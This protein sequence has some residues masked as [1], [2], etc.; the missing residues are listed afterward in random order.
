MLSSVDFLFSSDGQLTCVLK[1]FSVGG[2]LPR[3]PGSLGTEGAVGGNIALT[4]VWGLIP[5]G[6]LS[7]SSLVLSESCSCVGYKVS[8]QFREKL[9]VEASSKSDSSTAALASN[10][11]CLGSPNPPDIPKSEE[12]SSPALFP[13]GVL[14][15]GEREDELTPVG[16]GLLPQHL[17]KPAL[18]CHCRKNQQK[19]S[20]NI[21]EEAQ[22][23]VLQTSSCWLDVTP[24]GST[25]NS[26]CGSSFP[27]PSP[28]PLTVS[29]RPVP[30]PSENESVLAFTIEAPV[31]ALDEIENVISEDLSPLFQSVCLFLA[32][33]RCNLVSEKEGEDN[34]RGREV[35]VYMCDK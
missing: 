30:V 19:D 9:R 29:P 33:N 17:R 25:E 15:L 16:A 8:Q 23:E 31:P 14:A 12:H 2:S 26:I 28:D 1:T 11:K 18:L 4:T 10:I 34:W 7:P 3:S 32:K 35:C 20:P 24:P 13:P 6:F 5:A 22:N 27:P 21:E